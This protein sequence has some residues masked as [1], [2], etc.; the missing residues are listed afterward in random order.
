MK[1]TTFD[2]LVGFLQGVFWAFT[3]IGA[4]ITF[5]FVNSLFDTPLAV[6][7]TTLYLFVSLLGLLFLETMRTYRL[8]ADE[9]A[10]QT[11]LL[12]EIRELLKKEHT[13]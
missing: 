9:V 2:A 11:R 7:A 3:L 8:K 10:A 6:F 5:H 1:R 12:Q 13:A 4:W